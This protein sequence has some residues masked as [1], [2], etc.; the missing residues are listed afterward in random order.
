[1]IKS[2]ALYYTKLL[3]RGNAFSNAFKVFFDKTSAVTP[4]GMTYAYVPNLCL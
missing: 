3:F 1:M 2:A 4:K